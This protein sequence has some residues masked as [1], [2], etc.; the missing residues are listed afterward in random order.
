MKTDMKYMVL[1]LLFITM[2]AYGQDFLFIKGKAFS[3]FIVPKEHLV[4][5]SIE[6]QQERFTPSKDDVEKA[7]LLLLSNTDYLKKSQGNVFPGYPVIYKNRS[8]YI[9]QYVGFKDKSGDDVIWIN[10]LSKKNI[11]HSKLGKDIVNVLDGGSYYWSVF[12]NIT[13][14][15]V[16]G[17]QINGLG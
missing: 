1:L 5:R 9:R 14:G 11:A 6:N 16:F 13:T 4:F 2:N 15:A 12:V 3:G 8:K 10:F 7:E 17:V